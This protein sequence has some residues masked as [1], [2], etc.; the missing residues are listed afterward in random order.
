MRL[1]VFR[2][3]WVE[4]PPGEP[5]IRRQVLPNSGRDLAND[6]VDCPQSVNP[7]IADLTH[8]DRISSW[9]NASSSY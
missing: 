3:P 5:C 1:A 4:A 6:S 2:I 9:A 8:S 7:T